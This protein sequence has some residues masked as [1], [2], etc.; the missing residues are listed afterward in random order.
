MEAF[1]PWLLIKL[2]GKPE[3]LNVAFATQRHETPNNA[4]SEFSWEWNPQGQ[5]D[6][7]KPDTWLK[8]TENG[9]YKAKAA[10]KVI[11]GSASDWADYE[12]ETKRL[13]FPDGVRYVEHKITRGSDGLYVLTDAVQRLYLTEKEW[14]E[15]TSIEVLV[16]NKYGNS[17]SYALDGRRLQRA[18]HRGRD[19]SRGRDEKRRDLQ[20]YY[21]GVL[22]SGLRA[23]LRRGEQVRRPV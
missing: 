16:A 17:V 2:D 15:N 5:A 4:G 14:W 18:V 3:Y 20:A 10:D 7:Y 19:E 1:I 8:F 6:W 12:G 9:L 13:N 22:Y 21:R 11:D 23:R